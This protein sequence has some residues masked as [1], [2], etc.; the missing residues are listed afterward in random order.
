[1]ET[2]T[3]NYNQLKHRVVET[4]PSGHI[5]ITPPYVQRGHE[6]E[7]QDVVQERI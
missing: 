1:M 6:F 4:Y 7:E 5:C 2:T 3:E